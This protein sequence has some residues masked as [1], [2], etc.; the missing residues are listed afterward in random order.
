MV[1]EH[2]KLYRLWVV[3]NILIKETESSEKIFFISDLIQVDE[4]Q[5]MLQSRIG[6]VLEKYRG[7]KSVEKKFPHNCLETIWA[8]L[9]IDMDYA[10]EPLTENRKKQTPLTLNLKQ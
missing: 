9:Y 1:A 4:K 5:K 10:A 8:F 7:Q 2:I 6:K 3:W